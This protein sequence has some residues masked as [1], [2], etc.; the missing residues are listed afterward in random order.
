MTHPLNKTDFLPKSYLNV[1]SNK[2][3]LLALKTGD[4]KV[5]SDK[6]HCAQKGEEKH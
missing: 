4:L 5:Y 3:D 6:E 2:R 1:S